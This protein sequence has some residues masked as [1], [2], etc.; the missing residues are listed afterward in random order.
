MTTREENLEKLS[1]IAMFPTNWNNNGAKAFPTQ[2]INKIR[3]LLSVLE[4][5]PEIFPTPLGTIQLEYDKNDGSHLEIEIGT[6]E[7]AKVY[8]FYDS[9]NDEQTSISS[10]VDEISKVV[11]D[12]MTYKHQKLENQYIQTPELNEYRYLDPFW[13]DMIAEGL[14]KGAKKYPNNTWKQIPPEEHTWRA[15]RHLIEFLKKQ[16]PEDLIHA[17]MRCMLAYS[18]FANSLDRKQDSNKNVENLLDNPLFF[19]G[20]LKNE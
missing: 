7:L 4:I 1:Q 19:T 18:T 10:S 5:Q 14:T 11:E 16:N 2:L 13:L 9:F 20:G 17:S 15:V 6:G 12:F 8:K 3:R